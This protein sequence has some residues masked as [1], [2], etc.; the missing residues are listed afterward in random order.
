[1]DFLSPPAVIEALRRR[2][3]HGIFGY[4]APPAALSETIIAMLSRRFN[5]QVQPQWLVWLPGLVTGINV[6][7]RAVGAAGDEVLTTI[8]VYPPFLSAPSHSSRRLRTV[9][10]LHQNNR[11]T[12]D[13]PRLEEAIADRTRLFLLCSPYNPTGRV[14]SRAELEKLAA[15]CLHHN[16]IICSD[17][18]HSDLILDQDRHH[19][20]TATLGEE[21]AR[22][23]IT[24]MAP[25]K[26]YNIPGLGFSFAVIPDRDLR[27]AFRGAMAGIVPE[28]NL[29]GYTAALAAYRE[30]GE[31][32][33]ALL[34]YLRAN[35]DLVDAAI[36][37]IP[38]LSVARSEAT[39]LA[40]IDTRAAALANPGSFFEAAGVGL[41]DGVPFG[42]PGFVRLNFGCPRAV[43]RQ[44]L[45]RMKLALEAAERK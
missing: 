43:L 18:I 25:S 24:L 38:G 27:D 44:A 3:E 8:P 35:R 21:V 31:W 36:P 15:I 2:V 16:L 34:A 12:F 42:G 41:S 14:F 22:R 11:W 29:F 37:A 6:A 39:Y 7:C 9:P 19:L 28:I 1:M 26:T 30:G 17:E 23:T 40:W 4:T 45:T 13:F 32:L 10:L 20:P 33:A 5:W